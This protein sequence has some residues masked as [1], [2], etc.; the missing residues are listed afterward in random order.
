MKQRSDEV[1]PGRAA[2]SVGDPGTPAP[3]G[4]QR[5]LL[6]D[7]AR[8]E[9]GHTPSRS[10]SEYWNGDVP[11]VGIVDARINHGRV[12]QDTLQTITEEGLA[13][14]AA[15]LLPAQTVCLS[16]TA[17]VGYV[18]ILGRTMATSQDFV[19]W[20]CSDALDP[21]FL[22][23]ALLAEGDHLKGFGKGSTHTTIYFPE[24]LAF[25]IDLPSIPEQRRIVE[26]AKALFALANTLSRRL[27]V[28]I[29]RTDKLPQ[30]IL[31]KAFRGELVPTEAELARAEGRDYEPASAL[32]ERI[33]NEREAAGP[34]AAR[35]RKKAAPEKAPAKTKR[36]AAR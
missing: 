25:C 21:E 30:A 9:S 7:V 16:R 13:N 12:I 1:I 22:M 4:W 35:G 10:H 6:T 11:W 31:A 20:I 19:N 5:V 34:T 24:A 17:S 27:A 15:R 28:A 8:M 36:S 26:K 29:A 32:L 14:S 18:T 3:E 2:I 33:R 23:Y